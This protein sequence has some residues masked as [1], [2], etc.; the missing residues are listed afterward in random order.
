VL[1]LGANAL[2]TAAVKAFVSN[3]AWDLFEL[4]LQHN[5]IGAADMK[6]LIERFPNTVIEV[7]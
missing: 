2:G 6:A 4:K 1:D 5:S 3:T 7:R